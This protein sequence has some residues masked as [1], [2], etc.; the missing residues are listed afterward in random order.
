VLLEVD[1]NPRDPPDEDEEAI[2]ALMEGG[3]GMFGGMAGAGAEVGPLCR[4]ESSC[5]PALETARFQ[6]LRLP[7]DPS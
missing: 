4:F 7:L 5:D 2:R 3:G 6:P 1:L